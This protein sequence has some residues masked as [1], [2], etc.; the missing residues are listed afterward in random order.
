MKPATAKRKGA[1][2]EQMWVDYLREHGWPFA[3]RR[4]LAGVADRGDVAGVPGVTCEIKS[5][6]SIDLA[7]WMD[8]LDV[9]MANDKTSVGYVVIRPRKRPQAEDWWCVLPAPVLV[10]LLKAA[11]W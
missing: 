9:E 1:T 10:D 7:G 5:G 3:E 6:A 2:T 4:H 11:G 8:E